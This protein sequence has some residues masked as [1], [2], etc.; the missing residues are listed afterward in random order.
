MLP[1][2]QANRVVIRQG[3]ELT[4]LSASDLEVKDKISCYN[5]LSHLI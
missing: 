2:S 5:P 1:I 3:S 4:E